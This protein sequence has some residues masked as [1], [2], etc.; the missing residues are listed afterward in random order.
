MH[1]KF[2]MSLKEWCL[3]FSFLR[4]NKFL[5]EKKTYAYLD[6]NLSSAME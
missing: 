3:F 6:I 1:R 4:E 2:S 5:G